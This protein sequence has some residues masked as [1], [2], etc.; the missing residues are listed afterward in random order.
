MI[1]FFD[2]PQQSGKSS[3]ISELSKIG[4]GKGLK[5][6]FSKYTQEYGFILD[7]GLK[8]FQIG[9]DMATLYYLSSLP[10]PEENYLMDRG[11]LSTLFYSLTHSRLD[12]VELSNLSKEVNYYQKLGNI[13]FVFIVPKYR[14]KL[15]RDKLDGFDGLDLDN[16]LKSDLNQFY[17][18]AEYHNLDFIKFENDFSKPIEENA[19]RLAEILWGD[20]N[21]DKDF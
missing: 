4:F 13:K 2:G 15:I 19:K 21:G 10:Q 11:P 6:P 20:I 16:R 8:G 9:K 1:I 17:K 14:P 5:F 18:F 3:L 7:Q 12:A